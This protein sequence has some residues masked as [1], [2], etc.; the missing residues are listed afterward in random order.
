MKSNIF[1]V[2]MQ[3]LVNLPALISSAE[4]AFSGKPGSGEEKKKLVMNAVVTGLTIASEL[5]KEKITQK[6]SAS[7][8]SNVSELTDAT[9][10][11]MNTVELFKK[12][13]PTA[14]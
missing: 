3:L 9:V 1:S 12:P 8:V 5:T 13:E 10:D 6:Q 4:V 2:I 14:E 7:I 11:I